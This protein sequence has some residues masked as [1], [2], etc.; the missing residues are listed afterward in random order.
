MP[1]T[2]IELKGVKE[3]QA[4]LRRLAA[5]T[6]DQ[7]GAALRL[8]GERI[9]TRSKREFV[10]VAAQ[11]G[12][13]RAS[14]HVTGPVRKGKDVEVTMAYGG[15][16]AAYA[17]AIHEHPSEHSPPTWEG[18]AIDGIDW[19]LPGTGPKYLQ[20]PMD[21]AV[22]ELPERIAAHLKGLVEG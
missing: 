3:M 5:K 8:E 7:M 11:G 13:L 21:E 1:T 17:L 16:A 9:M 12:T 19:H 22:P 10:P 4:K 20:K 6:P 14:G 2:G 18:K 15:A